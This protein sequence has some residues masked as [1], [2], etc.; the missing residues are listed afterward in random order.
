MQKIKNYSLKVYS[1]SWKDYKNKILQKK[2][3]EKL[4]SEGDARL[5]YQE[6]LAS[7]SSDHSRNLQINALKCIINPLYR[8]LQNNFSHWKRVTNHFK[9][10][11]PAV[12]NLIFKHYHL[13]IFCAFRYGS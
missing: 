8:G 5:H 2:T 11:L 1:Y 13:Q 3:V 4:H 6:Q 10:S 12:K 7:L 9:N